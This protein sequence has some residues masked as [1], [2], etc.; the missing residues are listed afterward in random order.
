MT[1]LFVVFFLNGEINLPDLVNKTPAQI[2]N[3]LGKVSKTEPY[4]PYDRFCVCERVYYLDNQVSIVYV[5]GKSER[6]FIDPRIKILNRDRA[7]ILLFQRWE[8][9]IEVIVKGKDCCESV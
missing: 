1:L 9:E 5:D 7:K 6:I 2:E 3:L 8:K 4:K